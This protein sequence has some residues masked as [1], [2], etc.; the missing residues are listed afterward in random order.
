MGVDEAL[1][2]LN[3][4]HSGENSPLLEHVVTAFVLP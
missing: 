1:Y 2:F 3:Y 4:S